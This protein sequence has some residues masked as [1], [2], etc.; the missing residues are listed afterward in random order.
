MQQN[1]NGKKIMGFILENSQEP[2]D[3]ILNL[4]AAL[5]TVAESC[6]ISTQELK[7]LLER[8]LKSYDRVTKN[9]PTNKE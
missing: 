3:A 9:A 5:G 1:N 6:N 4:M 7:L 8:F 2:R